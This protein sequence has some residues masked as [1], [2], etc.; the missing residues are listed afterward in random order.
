MEYWG[1]PIVR[2]LVLP[3]FAASKMTP[4]TCPLV[5]HPSSNQ[6]HRASN[7]EHKSSNQEHK[8]SFVIEELL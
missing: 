3:V 1:G 6:K 8:S 2:Y 7:Q 5:V 4:H